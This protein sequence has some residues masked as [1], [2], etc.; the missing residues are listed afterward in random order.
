MADSDD[1]VI[2]KR[3]DEDLVDEFC[4]ELAMALRRILGLL[5]PWADPDEEEGD[6]DA[7][8]QP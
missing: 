6:G 5:A 4:Y 3:A 8:R 1:A 7:T 2:T